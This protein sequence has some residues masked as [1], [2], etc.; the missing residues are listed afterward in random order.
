MI[1]YILILLLITF[2]LHAQVTGIR[3]ARVVGNLNI[4]TQY[5][6][7]GDE[8]FA[9]GFNIEKYYTDGSVQSISMSVVDQNELEYDRLVKEVPYVVYRLKDE[10]IY[11]DYDP[12]LFFN[13]MKNKGY[14]N[15]EIK[16][17]N[18]LIKLLF[19]W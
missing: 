18:N 14:T 4:G 13:F 2:S 11:F 7:I 16:Y 15:K 12:V 5:L 19:E 3:D 8:Y 10:E 9:S 1:K 6:L 17:I